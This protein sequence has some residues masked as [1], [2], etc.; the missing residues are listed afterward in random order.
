[1]AAD[2]LR[3]SVE[4][5]A[6]D[7]PAAPDTDHLAGLNLL[8]RDDGLAT[9]HIIVLNFALIGEVSRLTFAHETSAMARRAGRFASEVS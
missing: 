3:Q 9:S 7:D 1:M 4:I 2:L 6:C 8:Q 5:V